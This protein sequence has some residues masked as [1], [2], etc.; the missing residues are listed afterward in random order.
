MKEENAMSGKCGYA[1]SIANA[2]AQKITAPAQ[3]T[4][5]KKAT[6]KKGTDLRS[7]K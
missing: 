2:S 3:K 6:V 5:A 4:V 7:S 1:G